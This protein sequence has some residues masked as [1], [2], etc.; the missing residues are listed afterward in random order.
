[1]PE[2][3]APTDCDLIFINRQQSFLRAVDVEQLI[4]A[5]HAARLF[6]DVTGKLDLS[7]FYAAIKTKRGRA[8]RPTFDPRLL[9]TVWLYAY[10]RGIDRRQLEFPTDDN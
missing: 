6:W 3:A 1:V 9:I 8:G 7:A 2:P 4:P 5:D 10:K